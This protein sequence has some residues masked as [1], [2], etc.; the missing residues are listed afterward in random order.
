MEEVDMKK[1][2]A[3]VVV[4][5]V[6]CTTMAWAVDVFDAAL[7][8]KPLPS[9]ADRAG[10]CSLTAVPDTAT[11]AR[12]WGSSTFNIGSGMAM[13]VDALSEDTTAG[14]SVPFLPFHA[15]SVDLN[16]VV[17]NDDTLEV[18]RTVTYQI[19]FA[20]PKDFSSGSATE[21]CQGPGTVF[22]TYTL[23]H[24]MVRG[25]YD[26]NGIGFIILVSVPVDVC[27][28]RPFFLIATLTSWDGAN[29]IPPGDISSAFG[30]PSLIWHGQH[31]AWVQ[32][33]KRCDNW[34]SLQAALGYGCWLLS[35]FDIGY[36]CGTE[37]V[38]PG[39]TACF[40]GAGFMYVNGDAGV[41]CAPAT[42]AP[43]PNNYPGDDAS[44][45]IIVN[46]SPWSMLVNLCNFTSDY[47]YYYDSQAAATT[48]RRFTGRGNDAVLQIEYNAALPQACWNITLTPQCPA[49]NILRLRTWLYDATYGY[50]LNW[51]TPQ[52]PVPP[53]GQTYIQCD[54]P[55]RYLLFIDGYPCCCPVMVTYSGDTPLPVELTSFQAVPGN[56]E[57]TLVWTTASE[58]N[59]DFFQIS[60]DGEVTTEVTATNSPTGHTYSFVDRGLVNGQRY[61]YQLAAYEM[62]GTVHLFAPQSAT[63]AAGIVTEYA[64]HQNYPNPFN[65][66]TSIAYAVKDA[67]LVTLKV[68]S[69]DGR[70]VAT[71]VNG[72]L[73][74]GAYT[75][76][77]DAKDLA[78]GVYLYK[79][80][81]NGYSATHKMVLMK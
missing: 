21:D 12:L 71:L 7:V 70:E 28:D 64:L 65:P 9:R 69:I 45:P 11:V 60:R 52:Y 78:S 50:T 81:V 74:A 49:P 8:N 43:L 22:A 23:T 67:G 56:G 19:D 62:D 34:L 55:D 18:G 76:N 25:D 79:L 16:L 30:A 77:F 61:E 58:R 27:I 37:P 66:S 13:Y 57:V 42:C 1:A 6:A 80:E 51:G 63:P 47:N 24:V 4:C 46:S 36:G 15:T 33:G 17:Y 31:D 5:L 73:P 32:P 39:F 14:C 40:P 20:C 3:L 41:Q 72:V 75:V 10:S 54:L 53:A 44:N 35:G 59:L 68:Y 48:T 38:P 29:S 2:I 26:A